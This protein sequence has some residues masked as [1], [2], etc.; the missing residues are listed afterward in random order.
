MKISKI[1]NRV[2][3]KATPQRRMIYEIMFE[4]GH[5]SIDDIITKVNQKSP[6]MT[7]S[8]IYRILDSFSEVGLVSKLSYPNGKCFYD[9][10]VYEHYHIFK[11]NQIIDYIDPELTTLIRNHLEEKSFEHF[12]SIERISIQIA[13]N[14]Q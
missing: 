9:I 10:T 14:N 1:L 11:D 4:L 5:S 6:E 13:V 7:L 3:L 8:T 2:G 12:D